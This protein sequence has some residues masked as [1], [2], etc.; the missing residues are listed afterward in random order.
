[1]RGEMKV[2]M[3]DPSAKDV[4]IDELGLG[5]LLQG[6]GDQGQCRHE[7]PGLIPSQ[8]GDVLY[9]ALRFQARKPCSLALLCN[10]EAP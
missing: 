10:G 1:M 8:L 4:H 6:V 5:R 3:R 7:R 2:E 9:V